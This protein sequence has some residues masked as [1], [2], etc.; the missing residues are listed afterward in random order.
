MRLKFRDLASLRALPHPA[1]KIHKRLAWPDSS[2]GVR[3]RCGR[4]CGHVCVRAYARATRLHRPGYPSGACP[5]PTPTRPAP[6]AHSYECP[7]DAL[8]SFYR[9]PARLMLSIDN[10][11]SNGAQLSQAGLEFNY[12]GDV[13]CRY[14]ALVN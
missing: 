3:L 8:A 10:M 11:H 6:P 5:A 1:L 14:N 4:A 2:W 13:S 12:E 9:P 7:L